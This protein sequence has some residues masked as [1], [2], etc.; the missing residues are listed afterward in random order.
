MVRCA[1]GGVVEGMSTI[2]A[3]AKEP[4]TIRRA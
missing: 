1:P 4:T 2:D 3:I